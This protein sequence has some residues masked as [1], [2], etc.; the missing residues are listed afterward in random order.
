MFEYLINPTPTELVLTVAR[1]GVRNVTVFQSDLTRHDRIGAS[2]TALQASL[3]STAEHLA[4]RSGDLSSAGLTKEANG[5]IDRS[6]KPAYGKAV[7]A[8]RETRD[9][10]E[11]D[12]QA[13]T[14]PTFGPDH[15]PAVRS[16]MRAWGGGQ[17]MP[18][19]VQAALADPILAGAIVEG[20]LTRSGLP[21]DVFEQIATEG[22]MGR[23]AA[24]FRT[25]PAFQTDPTPDHPLG[26]EFDTESARSAA[27]RQFNKIKDERALI[28]RV[29]ALLISAIDAIAVMAADNRA[30]AFAR[31]AA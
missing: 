30:G 8:A 2:L 16:E 7:S 3:A 5:Q 13:F 25:Q 18:A 11:A 23:L 28:G 26:G 29:P 21:V 10:V 22:A 1:N 20:G 31:V 12:W 14:V 24:S 4:K 6:I 17:K 19:L 15:P 9:A 27:E